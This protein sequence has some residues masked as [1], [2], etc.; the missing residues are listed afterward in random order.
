MKIDLIALR[1]EV[2]K[3]RELSHHN[4]IKYLDVDTA[5]EKQTINILM[6]YM[7]GGSVRNLLDKFGPLDEKI[8]KIYMKQVLEGLKY[9]HANNIAHNNL[10]CSNILVAN[11]G[12]IK[13]S[14]FAITKCVFTPKP[15]KKSTCNGTDRAAS[16]EKTKNSLF[17]KAPEVIES[18]R[19]DK[20]ADIW[21]L[22]CLMFEMKTG[23]PPWTQAGGDA[24]KILE[25]ISSSLNGPELPKGALSPQARTWL[26]R[27]FEKRAEDRPSVEEL[28]SDPFMAE[29]N[30]D[31]QAKRVP[32][33]SMECESVPEERK[34]IHNSKD[35]PSMDFGF[36]EYSTSKENEALNSN[37]TAEPKPPQNAEADAEAKAKEQRRKK[38]E[39]AL[40][41]ELEKKKLQNT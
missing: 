38:W 2:E 12:T 28:L 39:E 23:N 19:E 18:A 33:D 30:D 8:I 25:S 20:S 10:K 32:E 36:E 29:E 31:C 9:L 37:H 22:G 5:T 17:W 24:G 13:L 1:K 3:L 27:C 7:P 40:R 4:I 6:E 26:C 11:E 16:S 34:S 35:R 21:S 41:Q 15:D 14:D